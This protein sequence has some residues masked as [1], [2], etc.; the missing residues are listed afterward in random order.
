MEEDNFH[1]QVEYTLIQLSMEEEYFNLDKI[2]QKFHYSPLHQ[3]HQ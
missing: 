1:S 3:I 2:I